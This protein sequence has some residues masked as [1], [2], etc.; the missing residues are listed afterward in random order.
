MYL[1]PADLYSKEFLMV[2]AMAIYLDLISNE[3]LVN[4]F[5]AGQKQDTITKE[6]MSRVVAH[7]PVY[8]ARQ[9]RKSKRS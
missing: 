8:A 7:R 4:L 1:L 9:A 6:L 5:T 3:E 2:L